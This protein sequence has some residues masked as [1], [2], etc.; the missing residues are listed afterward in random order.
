MHE[1]EH[2]RAGVGSPRSLFRKGGR[3]PLLIRCAAGRSLGAHS[4]GRP[5][6]AE[7]SARAGQAPQRFPERRRFSTRSGC[8][9]EK[10][11]DSRTSPHPALDGSAHPPL[12][13][14]GSC[15]GG[16]GFRI[17]QTFRQKVAGSQLSTPAPRRTPRETAAPTLC[18][19]AP[20]RAAEATYQYSSVTDRGNRMGRAA[21]SPNLKLLLEKETRRCRR[22]KLSA[23]TIRASKDGIVP[24]ARSRF[25]C[26]STSS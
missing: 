10:R 1:N 23:Q 20:D 9:E 6:R 17:Y 13:R 18:S 16:S 25:T 3:T 12:R 11:I 22:P 15:G 26:A 8:A 14:T 19:A 5:P 2:C 24:S 21:A 4:C 7:T